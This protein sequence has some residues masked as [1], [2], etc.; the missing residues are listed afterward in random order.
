MMKGIYKWFFAVLLFGFLA[1]QDDE[2]IELNDNIDAAIE[3]YVRRFQTEADT[4]GVEVD[5][6]NLTA[7]LSDIDREDVAG[8]C[9]SYTDGSREVVIDKSVWDRSG[10]LIREFIVFHE[11]GHCILDR[12]HDE[13]QN[14]NGTCASIMHSGTSNCRFNYSEL[15]RSGYLDELFG[16]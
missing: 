12:A 10:D 16:G 3:M 4:R 13:S 5:F 11:L 1:C 6:E 9:I 8:Q 14:T 2:P 7:N 15:T